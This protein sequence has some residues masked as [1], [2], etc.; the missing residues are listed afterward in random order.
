[1]NVG[2]FVTV[3]IYGCVPDVLAPSWM[4]KMSKLLMPSMSSEGLTLVTFRGFRN[5]D[6]IK[7]NLLWV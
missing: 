3:S 2:Y 1:M 7:N 4:T 6:I 5:L